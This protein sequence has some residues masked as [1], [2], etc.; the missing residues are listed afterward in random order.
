[1]SSSRLSRGYRLKNRPSLLISRRTDKE[2]SPGPS[3][4]SSLQNRM[5]RV[6]AGQL[7]S[8][9]R[10]WTTSHPPIVTPEHLTIT[11]PVP[12]SIN[13]QYATVN[14]RRLLSSTGRAYKTQVGQLLW[15]AF[16][17]SPSRMALH[18]RLRTEPL[19]ISIRF[20]F[21]SSL[22]RDLDGGLKITQDAVC[23]GLGI[24]DNRIV[25][26]HL[27]KHVDKANPR[28]EVSLSTIPTSGLS[29]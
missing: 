27:Y 3:T 15:M 23:E 29:M 12:P 5:A 4:R 18:D 16:T 28:I 22:R 20:F 21:A 26:T 10:A 1:M 11:F 9:T 6:T 17:Q 8:G 25:E 13:H 7:T 24:N 19:V 14:G 2:V